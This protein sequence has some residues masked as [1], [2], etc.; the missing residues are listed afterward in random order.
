[1]SSRLHRKTI[2]FQGRTHGNRHRRSA[3]RCATHINRP[4]VGSI[5]SGPV[6]F[7]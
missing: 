3:W 6:V 7:D 4:G 5:L 1:L 2:I